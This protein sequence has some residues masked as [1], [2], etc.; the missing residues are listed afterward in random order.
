M[1]LTLGLVGG[2]RK[3]DFTAESKS[4]SNF[5][6]LERKFV[7]ELPEGFCDAD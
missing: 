4:P 7:E 2:F 1:D 5:S 3:K 6:S